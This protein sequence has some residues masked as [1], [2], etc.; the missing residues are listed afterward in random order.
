MDNRFYWYWLCNIPGVGNVKTE[1][2]LNTFGTPKEIYNASEKFIK[3]TNILTDK[4]IQYFSESKH[5]IGLYDNYLKMIK[6]G[7]RMITI[8]DKE[9]PQRL[10]NIYN[11]PVCIYLLGKLPEE[12]V[13][14]V[15]IVGA[16]AC[17]EYGRNVAYNLAKQLTLAGV[18]VVSGMARGIDTAAHKGAIE[19]NPEVVNDRANMGKTFAILAGGVD[20][21]YPRQNIELYMQIKERGAII[22]EYAPGTQHMSNHFPLRNRIISGLSDVVV[23]VE[24][25]E[26][27]GSL[28]TVDMA[29]EQ[30]K[31]VMVVPGRI[32]DNLSK[33]C[34]GL[35]KQGAGIV[36]NVNDVLDVLR[37]E[38][39]LYNNHFSEVIKT[40][41]NDAFNGPFK[42][43]STGMSE[44]FVDKKFL[45]PL[46]RVEEMLY[47]CV[48]LTPK[49]FNQLTEESGLDMAQVAESIVNLEFKGYIKEY[50]YGYYV[51]T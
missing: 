11:R 38:N 24:A 1:S 42:D 40:S 48:D 27:S 6:D 20:I 29:L 4:D 39:L 15:A 3:A 2:L 31:Q 7:I 35:I 21:C 33:G 49:N 36:C 28:I 45:N 32:T 43:A 30:N 50:S 51:R 16:R 14:S 9:Y 10:I 19:M 41:E 37:S 22:S 44:T 34:N 5:D 25:R 26:K 23:V 18:N 46:A 8:E 17:S 12:I 47:S 13:P